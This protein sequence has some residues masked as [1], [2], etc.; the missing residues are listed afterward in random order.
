MHSAANSHSL[1]ENELLALSGSRRYSTNSLSEL[2]HKA[3][4]SHASLD[5]VLVLGLAAAKQL[6]RGI[7]SHG[8]LENADRPT[9]GVTNDSER[10]IAESSRCG[11]KPKH[12]ANLILCISTSPWSDDED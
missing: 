2:L 7:A 11:R 12:V 4:P 6:S 1:N 5:N 9:C 8:L 3:C 10:V